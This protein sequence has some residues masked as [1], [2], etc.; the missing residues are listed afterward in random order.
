MDITIDQTRHNT[1]HKAN[2]LRAAWSAPAQP[3]LP[4]YNPIP[5]SESVRAERLQQIGHDPPVSTRPLL[6]A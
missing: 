4:Y 2:S 6:Y 1:S 3:P 5:P